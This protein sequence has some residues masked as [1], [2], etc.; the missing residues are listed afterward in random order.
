[1]LLLS[2]L[3]YLFVQLDAAWLVDVLLDRQ[4]PPFAPALVD[5]PECL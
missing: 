3:Q 5:H 2:L 4:P 1:M